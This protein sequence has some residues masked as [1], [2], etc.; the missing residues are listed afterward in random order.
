M[1]LSET[2]SFLVASVVEVELT[3]IAV[4]NSFSACT[5]VVVAVV[6][7]MLDGCSDREV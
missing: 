5:L 7:A 6:A 4:S 2:I 1:I 3:V